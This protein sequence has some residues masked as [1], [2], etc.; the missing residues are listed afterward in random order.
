[1]SISLRVFSSEFCLFLLVSAKR[2]HGVRTLCRRLSI[3]DTTTTIRTVC[4]AKQA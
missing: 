1:M 4:C 3:I 2:N